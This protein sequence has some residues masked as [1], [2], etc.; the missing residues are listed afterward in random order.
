MCSFQTSEEVTK[1]SQSEGPDLRHHEQMSGVQATFQKQVKALCTT[2]VE[3]GNP[4]LEESKDLLVLDTRDIVDT[5]VAE[6]VTKIEELGK[7]QFKAFVADRLEKQTVSLFEPIK[8]NNLALFSSPPPSKA[9]SSD[10]MQIASLKSNCSLFSRLYISCQVRDGDLEAFFSHENQSFPPALTQ[11]G[12][13]RS[14]TKS[15]LLHCLDKIIPGQAEAPSVGMMLLD[16]A[17]IVN[18]LK[19]GPS[20]TFQEYSQ[21]VF[22]L[23]WKVSSEVSKGLMWYGTS[24]TR[25]ASRQQPGAR[26]ERGSE[27]VSSPTPKFLAI[28]QRSSGLTKI[29]RNF[30][31][32]SLISLAQL[33]L[34]LVR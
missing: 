28:G 26:E 25:T 19:P 7:T 34:N 20:R 6:T 16:G 5:S 31:T 14:G 32:S 33:T 24:T 10:K 27:G 29:S 2:F 12:Q 3:M 23:M 4:F 21:G 13:L 8:R 22:F 18:M 9:K 15:D 1:K 30:L 17:T 11:F